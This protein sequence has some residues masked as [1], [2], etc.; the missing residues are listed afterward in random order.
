MRGEHRVSMRPA[1]DAKYESIDCAIARIG[2][3]KTLKLGFVGNEYYAGE[4]R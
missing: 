2:R 1:P 4:E 3:V